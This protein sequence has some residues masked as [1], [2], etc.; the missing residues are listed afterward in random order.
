MSG[1]YQSGELHLGALGRNS[2]LGGASRDSILYLLA[3]LLGVIQL[4]TV[5]A[6]RQ[7]DCRGCALP[8]SSGVIDYYVARAAWPAFGPTTPDA[9]QNMIAFYPL[10][11]RNGIIGT[12]H[13]LPVDLHNNITLAQAGFSSRRVGIDI[14]NQGALD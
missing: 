1:K 8:R 6:I 13:R 7:P 4:K 2:R 11:Q 3:H 12:P 9:Q 14:D 10:A 5:L